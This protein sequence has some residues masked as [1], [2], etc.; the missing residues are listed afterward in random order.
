MLAEALG[1]KIIQVLQTCIIT[2]MEIIMF[3]LLE[4]KAQSVQYFLYPRY[5]ILYFEFYYLSRLTGSSTH[6]KHAGSISFLL[7][8]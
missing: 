2:R 8:E 7:C 3:N 6:Q 5:P 4:P 1:N